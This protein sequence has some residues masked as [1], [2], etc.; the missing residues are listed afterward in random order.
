MK[1]ISSPLLVSVL[2]VTLGTGATAQGKLD[3]IP[4][5]KA[6]DLAKLAVSEKA[7]IFAFFNPSSSLET[8]F[9]NQLA[10]EASPHVA[11]LTI[12]LKSVE[13][14]VAKQYKILQTPAA[15]VMDRRRRVTGSS[16]NIEEI[17]GF[18]R[19]AEG[20]MRIDW[21][22]EGTALFESANAAAG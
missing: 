21:A 10:K 7:T 1:R 3:V 18:V 4:A 22:E 2:A 14:P 8:Q 16:S 20:V 17:R 6:T 19:K 9:V 15:V 11:V 5:N 12:G 13:E